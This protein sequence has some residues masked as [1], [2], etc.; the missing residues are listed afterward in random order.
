MGLCARDIVTVGPPTL[1][2]HRFLPVADHLSE[3]LGAPGRDW[4]LARF[5]QGLQI[6]MLDGRMGYVAFAAGRSAW[7]PIEGA[8]SFVVIED[9]RLVPGGDRPRLA[10]R[11]WHAA[12][13]WA[14]YYGFAGVLALAGSV[15]GLIAP[16]QLT[17]P[18]YHAVGEGPGGTRLMARIL[19]GPIDLP[20][21]PTGWTRRAAGSG[22]GLVVQTDGSH[23]WFERRAE[24]LLARARATGVPARHD[25][26]CDA[27]AVRGRA[28]HPS[29]VFSVL[30]DGV[31]IGG[32]E[33]PEGRLNRLLAA[34][35]PPAP[36]VA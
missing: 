11:L 34:H 19:Q 20:A 8:E 15:P 33:T 32:A 21:L 4:L 22:P 16:G 7:R 28:V 18:L 17:A 3:G 2:R 36:P 12:E 14:R 6:R 1:D 35:L 5:D 26:L 25:R 27:A 31:R 9:M 24:V 10:E 29:T 23:A 13:D 30:F